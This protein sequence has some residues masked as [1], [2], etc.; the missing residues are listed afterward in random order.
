[1]YKLNPNIKKILLEVIKYTSSGRGRKP[2]YDVEHY[3]DVIY[4]YIIV[5]V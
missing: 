2:N 4:F 3:L 1:M 5:T